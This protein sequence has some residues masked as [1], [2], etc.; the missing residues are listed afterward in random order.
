MCV[1]GLLEMSF[2]P[3]LHFSQDT[4]ALQQV[5]QFKVRLLPD[6]ATALRGQGGSSMCMGAETQKMVRDL[7]LVV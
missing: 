4:E 3:P 2:S 7:I 6:A 1:A 5:L